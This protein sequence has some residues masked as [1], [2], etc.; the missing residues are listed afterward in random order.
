M[1]IVSDTIILHRFLSSIFIGKFWVIYISLGYDNS[2]LKVVFADDRWTSCQASVIGEFSGF[3][4]AWEFSRQ[5]VARFVQVRHQVAQS[6][7]VCWIEIGDFSSDVYHF[8][9]ILIHFK[10]CDCFLVS[11]GPV[12]LQFTC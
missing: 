10:S 5:G 1:K 12:S 6:T 11:Y 8:W 9:G 4:V 2:F 7:A 3:C